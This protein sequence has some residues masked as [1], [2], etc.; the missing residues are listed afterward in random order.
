M[1]TPG[2]KLLVARLLAGLPVY[3]LSNI[4]WKTPGRRATTITYLLYTRGYSSMGCILQAIILSVAVVNP[5]RACAARVTVV[6]LCV[7]MCVCVRG[8]HLRLAQ[9]S[10]KLGIL[11]VSVSCWLVFK[12]G[13]FRIMASFRR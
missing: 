10:D 1:A 5:R 9:L 7:C 8:P 2:Y 6:V 13:V 4:A 12:K 11:A 3:A